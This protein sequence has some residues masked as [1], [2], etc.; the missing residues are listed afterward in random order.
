MHRY[1][2]KLR[3]ENTFFTCELKRNLILHLETQE[4]KIKHGTLPIL[5]VNQNCM[6][7]QLKEGFPKH[8]L[9][10]RLG[11]LFFFAHRVLL[12]FMP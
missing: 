3:I 6:H 5:Y 1:N 2:Q 10:N 4:V 7:T 12:A 11:K 8:A 9:Q